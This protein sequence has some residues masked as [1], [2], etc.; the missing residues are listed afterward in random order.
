MHPYSTDES[1]VSVYS[2]LAVI[3]VVASWMIVTIL[4]PFDWPEWLVSAP[5]LAG[6][7]GVIYGLFDRF[8]WKWRLWSCL[9]LVSIRDLSGTYEGDLISTWK[10]SSGDPTTR[11]IRIVITQTWTRLRVEMEVFG[12]SSSSVSTSALGSVTSDGTTSSLSYMY[13]NRV[14]PAVAD[15]DMGDHDGAADVRIYADGRLEGRY[16]NSRPRAGTIKAARV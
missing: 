6:A 4:S 13:R 3:A 9:N 5:S 16:F 7:F 1:R 11:T 8:I 10:D 15:E 14:N 2:F 12:D